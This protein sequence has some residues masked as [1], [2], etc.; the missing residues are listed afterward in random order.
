MCV[1]ME[2][3]NDLDD[4]SWLTQSDRIPQDPTVSFDLT[5][6]FFNEEVS[7]EENVSHGTKLYDGVYAEDI[8]DDEA[9]DQL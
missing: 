8:S 9:V 7:L 2:E 4:I 3:I 6:D 5:S 1:V